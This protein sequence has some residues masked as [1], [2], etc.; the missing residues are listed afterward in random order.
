M[1]A[2]FVGTMPPL[3]GRLAPI[4]FRRHHAVAPSGRHPESTIFLEMRRFAAGVVAAAIVSGVEAQSA[5]CRRADCD[6]KINPPRR[7][8]TVVPPGKA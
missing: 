7:H 1:A 4:K 3:R 5:S 6:G 8:P 2:E